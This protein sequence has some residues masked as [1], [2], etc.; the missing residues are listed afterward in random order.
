MWTPTFCISFVFA[1][2]GIFPPPLYSCSEVWGVQQKLWYGVNCCWRLLAFKLLF[3]RPIK[4]IVGAIEREHIAN[5]PHVNCSNYEPCIFQPRVCAADN[6][7]QIIKSAAWWFTAEEEASLP[8]SRRF[9]WAALENAFSTIS[10]TYSTPLCMSCRMYIYHPTN[11]ISTLN[12]C[13]APFLIS[14]WSSAISKCVHQSNHGW[15]NKIRFQVKFKKLVWDFLSRRAFTSK[16]K[17]LSSKFNLGHLELP[18]F[19]KCDH[20]NI[21]H[22]HD[23][24][25]DHHHH[26]WPSSCSHVQNFKTL[27]ARV[28]IV[29]GV[30]GKA[31]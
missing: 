22:H 31:Q 19:T 11:R 4:Q 3:T 10:K 20:D 27:Q 8:G 7:A 13:V 16:E 14:S 23:H 9:F 25:K 1:K 17:D 5:A 15:S 28:F 18:I 6:F 24:H 21:D 30:W 26:S 2:G 29:S 12:I